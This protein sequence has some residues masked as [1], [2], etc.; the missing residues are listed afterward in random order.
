MAIDW[1]KFDKKVNL[2]ALK[3]DIVAAEENSGDFPD[4]PEGKYE[5][6]VKNMELGK[7]KIKDDGSGGDP[8]LK[9]QFEILDGEFKGSLLFYNGV[10]QAHNEK[11]FGFQ[12]HKNNELLR[13]LWDA[14]HDEVAFDS[15]SE[16]NDLVLDIA[17]EIMED[18]WEYILEKGIT[19]KGYDTY[20]I[21][22]VLD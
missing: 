14:E 20:E 13:S 18:G 7:S 16:Y 12:V 11:A 17:E 9:V 3:D 15:F 8:M 4:I 2:D 1:G 21:V 22:E 5:V 10:M 19:N 6:S